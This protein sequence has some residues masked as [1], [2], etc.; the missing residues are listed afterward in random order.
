MPTKPTALSKGDLVALVA[1]AGPCD[2]GR[3]DAGI[4]ILESWGLRVDRLPPGDGRQL[5]Y[6]A[7]SDRCRG[8]RIEQAFGRAEVRAVFAARG[9][10][11][12]A[13]LYQALDLSIVR[14]NPKIFV[15]FSDVSLL[16]GRLLQETDL[17]CFHGPMIA[18]DLPRLGEQAQERFRR[19]LLAEDGWWEGGVRECWRGGVAQGRLVGGCLSILVTT[20][21]T[22]YEIQTADSVLFL[23]DVAE[24]PYRID[25]M[26][27][28]LKHAGK[29]HG[30][31]GLVLG[32]MID[33]DGG[34]GSSALREIVLDVL[35]DQSFPIVYGFDAGHGSGN[36]VLPLGCR[37][38]IDADKG[39]IELLEAPLVRP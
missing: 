5:G 30:V 9:G 15:G 16:L 2:A 26:L 28:H 7:G 3:L 36:V 4:S 25:R 27:Q 33:C 23:E 1:P 34:G 39:M 22:N 38:R 12:S 8:Q 18:A 10:Y 35:S 20:L 19:F 32:P 24:K 29:F 11:G 17:V 31:R 14:A 6:L 13:R 21:G 37:T